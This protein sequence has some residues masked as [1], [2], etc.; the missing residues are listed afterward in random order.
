[1]RKAGHHRLG[2]FGGEFGQHLAGLDDRLDGRQHVLAQAIADA[3]RHFVVSRAG[4]VHPAA[5]L[6]DVLD[7][8]RLDCGVDVLAVGEGVVARRLHVVE[9]FEDGRGVVAVDDT[10]F[11]EHHDVGAVD[12]EVRLED[13]F[14]GRETREE[15]A[16]GAAAETLAA[17]DIVATFLFAHVAIPLFDC[18]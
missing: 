7:D 16:G 11:V 17:N 12:G 5:A 15:P 18:R 4:G 10:L 9:R 3:G 6:A 1:M 8:G 13:A 2:V 14:V